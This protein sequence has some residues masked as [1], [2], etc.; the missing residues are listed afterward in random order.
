MRNFVFTTI[1]AIVFLFINS[2][3]SAQKND[4]NRIKGSGNLITKEIPVK[5]FD[6]LISSGVYSLLLSQGNTEQVK[7]EADDNLMD[8]V[9][10]ENEGS[11]LTIRMKKDANYSSKN[12][13]KVYVTFKKLK[14]MDLS[15]V[16]ETSSEESLT[17]DKLS[18]NNASVGSVNLDMAVHDF[19]M[20]N[21]S[22]GTVKLS[23]N[24]QNAVIKTNSVGS[25]KAGDFVVQVMEIENNGIGSAEVN[26]EKELNVTDSFMGKV[27]NRGNAAPK[28]KIVI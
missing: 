20:E 7:I 25:F 5:S 27:K 12:K 9:I 4:K 16:G 8:L 23:G 19:H 3:T 14:S 15:M 26:A 17:F 18:L 21:S 11:K 28:R 10:V 1:T 24:A 13:M 22:V 2:E 6:Q